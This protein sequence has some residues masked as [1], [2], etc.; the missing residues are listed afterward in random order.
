MIW[1]ALMSSGVDPLVAGLAIGL[2]A[3]A[4]TPSRGELEEAT[5]RVRAVPRGADARAGPVGH[6]SA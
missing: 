4:Y 3:P 1:S 6:R 5:G 2:A